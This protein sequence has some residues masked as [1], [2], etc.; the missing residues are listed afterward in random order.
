MTPT[1]NLANAAR[2]LLADH[3]DDGFDTVEHE[4]EVALDEFDAQEILK[5]DIR[6]RVSDRQLAEYFTE[7]AVKIGKEIGAT[8]VQVSDV[9][10]QAALQAMRRIANYADEMHRLIILLAQNVSLEDLVYKVRDTEG[11]GWDGPKVKGAGEAIAGMLGEYRLHQAQAAVDN[12][13]EAVDSHP[14]HA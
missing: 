3:Q 8:A 4:L 14:G 9:A 2:R 7:E 1:T 5:I 12:P 10:E 6:S 11:L 13:A